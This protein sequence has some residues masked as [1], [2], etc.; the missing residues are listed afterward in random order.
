VPS[1]AAVVIHL[2]S[3]IMLPSK[4]QLS[5]SLYFPFLTKLHK[6]KIHSFSLKMQDL[7]FVFRDARREHG[8]VNF[9]ED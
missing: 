3:C 9:E 6:L 8:I 5:T 2:N 4:N 7:N 1:T